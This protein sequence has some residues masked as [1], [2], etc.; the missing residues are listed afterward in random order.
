MREAYTRATDFCEQPQVSKFVE[1]LSD[2]LRCVNCEHTN[3]VYT[4]DVT[5]GG[6]DFMQDDERLFIAINKAWK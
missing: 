5:L 3:V 4:Q 1:A 6:N 2:R